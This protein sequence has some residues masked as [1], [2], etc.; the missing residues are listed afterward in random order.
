MKV[1]ISHIKADI[2]SL[3]GHTTVF[4]PVVDAVEDY[5]KS[6]GKNIISDYRISH[7]GDD[8]QITMV[9]N[10]GVDNPD[11]HGLA[12][13]AF[14][15]GTEVAKK[16]GLYGAGQDLL[17]DAFSGNVKGMG[18]GVAEMEITP[19]KSEPFIVYMMDKTEPGSFNYPI[20][21]MFGDP[22]NTPGLV[23]DPNMHAGFKFEVWDI[24]EGKRIMLSLPEQTYDLLALIG[25]KGR[26]VI[27]RVYT[28]EEH[29][30][31]PAENV[32]VISTDKLS[33]IAG[34][35]V[36]KDDPAAVVRI[37]SGLPAAGEALEPFAN[38]YLVSGWMRGSF[39]GPLMPVGI[40]NS[41]MTRFDGPPRVAALGFVL[42]DGR[43]AGPVDMF[44][45]IAFDYARTK[46]LE[47]ADYLRRMGVFE[48]H[49]L[50]DDDMEY[51][52]LPKILEKLSS[53]FE[54]LSDLNEL[55]E[56]Q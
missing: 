16:Y 26:Y 10:H 14:K 34:E 42:K 38:S 51:T 50:P 39:N 9:H 12:W 31:L 11:V 23:I 48:P 18:P 49:R 56:V 4:E 27:K 28:K 24:I 21:K 25:S 40:K 47:M 45:D 46:A 7:I 5:I 20:Y 8:I 32:A 52:A 55:K 2:G 54:K 33:F 53:K 17:K 36:G 15:A 3:P 30:K 44:D 41:R 29:T 35:Y 22:F 19:R 37:Q 13:N 1:T 43:L 6:N